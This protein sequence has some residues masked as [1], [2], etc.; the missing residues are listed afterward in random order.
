MS[1]TFMNAN[2]NAARTRTMTRVR[3]SRAAREGPRAARRRPG[4]GRPYSVTLVSDPL[5][6]MPSSPD[7]ARGDPARALGIQGCL[8]DHRGR[9]LVDDRALAGAGPSALSQQTVSSHRRH[10]FVDKPNGHRGDRVAQAGG[11]LTD[12]DGC[13]TFSS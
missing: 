13:W 4:L 12:L 8:E 3:I 9:G 2:T 5:W 6:L 7:L 11:E 1:L 10:A